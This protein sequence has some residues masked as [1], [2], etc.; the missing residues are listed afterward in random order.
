MRCRTA[1]ARMR[2]EPRLTICSKECAVWARKGRKRR[3]ESLEGPAWALWA[4]SNAASSIHQR[5]RFI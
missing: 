1:H 5:L 3:K 2:W 4:I